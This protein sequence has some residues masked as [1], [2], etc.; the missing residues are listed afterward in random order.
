MLKL[1]AGSAFSANMVGLT[2]ALM[3]TEDGHLD[4]VSMVDRPNL[5][6]F[7]TLTRGWTKS[8]ILLVICKLCWWVMFWP[9]VT[10]LHKSPR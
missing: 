8:P 9:P 5:S 7:L 3:Q 10:G 4:A 6:A 1:S 2:T